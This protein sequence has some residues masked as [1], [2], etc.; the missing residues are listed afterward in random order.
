M[1]CFSFDSDFD[2]PESEPHGED[3]EFDE[4]AYLK[5]RMENDDE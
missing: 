3:E 1:L 4:K 5:W 2:Q